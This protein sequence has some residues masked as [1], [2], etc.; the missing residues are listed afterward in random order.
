MAGLTEER[1]SELKEEYG[2]HDFQ[3]DALA[4]FDKVVG[5]SG[6]RI[7]ELAGSDLP[8]SVVSGIFGARQ[9][10]CIDDPEGHLQTHI[11]AKP[12]LKSHYEQE[13]FVPVTQATPDLL[14]YQYFV[15]LGDAAALPHWL[16]GHFDAIV[17]IAGFE[18]IADLP[19]T[20][21]KS[22]KALNELG[23]LA[24]DFGPIW[25]SVAGHHLDG[26]MDKAGAPVS[27]GR[28]TNPVPP[29]GHLLYDRSE[30]Y[31]IIKDKVA[32][33]QAELAIDLIY[34]HPRVNRL[35]TEDYIAVFLASA[36]RSFSWDSYWVRKPSPELQKRLMDRH[37]GRRDFSQASARVV[38]HKT[39]VSS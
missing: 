27:W 15:M 7:L 10:V 17:S 38:L 20:L 13:L 34:N 5:L 2:L 28:A 18:H 11:K 3:L 22:H 4:Y 31:E 8:R 37:P 36:F 23:M 33:G 30:L 25:S 6:K 21:D 9:W 32:D 19:T 24:A 35:F 12:K 16:F 29:W 1:R 14:K 39:K 26:L